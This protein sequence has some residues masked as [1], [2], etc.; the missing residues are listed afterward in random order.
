MCASAPLT[1][2]PGY[3]VDVSIPERE[4]N[5]AGRRRSDLPRDPHTHARRHARRSSAA[6]GLLAAEDGGSK[7]QWLASSASAASPPSAQCSAGSRSSPPAGC[8]RAATSA[9]R[10]RLHGSGP[11][12][13][14]AHRSVPE[15]NPE[16]IGRRGAPHTVRLDLADDGRRSR[17]RSSGFCSRLHFVWLA[18]WTIAAFLAAIANFSRRW[19]LALGGCAAPVPR[20]LRPLLRA[21]DRLRH[22]GREPVPGRRQPRLPVDIVL[23][24]P[25]HQITLFRG[26]LAIPALFIAGALVSCCSS[27]PCSAGSPPSRRA[28]C[29]PG[30]A[31][32][33]R[34]PSA[35][36]ADERVLAHR[37]RRLPHAGRRSTRRRSRADRRLPEPALPDGA[38]ASL[39][40]P[41]AV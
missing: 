14:A 7:A 25:E 34:S 16:A 2:A 6:A 10:A 12:H 37:H 31:A 1:R 3:P 20:R 33:V 19:S 38:P 24:P 32:S 4:P 35:T 30:F 9:R 21:P 22:A 8:R 26:F 29:R 41:E 40:E 27:S 11:L 13:G 28:E 23:D 18:L 5:R 15:L 39:D 36:A 17:R